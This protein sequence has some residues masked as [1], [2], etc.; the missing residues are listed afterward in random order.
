[1]KYVINVYGRDVICASCVNAPGSKDTYEWL[2]AVL[3]RKYPEDDLNFNYI[4]IDRN[5]NLSD[6]DESIIERI[7][8]DE[9]FYPLVTIN[10][11]IVQDGH[12]Q[13]KPIQ[14]SMAEQA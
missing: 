7:N 9:L 4:D 11:E 14:K 13:L 12:V 8:E 1:M 10:D 5:D 2:E 6:F 3:S